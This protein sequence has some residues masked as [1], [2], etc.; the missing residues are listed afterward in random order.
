M[1]NHHHVTTDTQFWINLNHSVNCQNSI[2]DGIRTRGNSAT[3][4]IRPT[5]VVVFVWSK[6]QWGSVAYQGKEKNAVHMLLFYP[7][8]NDV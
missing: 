3:N 7:V 8:C 5:A 2:K 1:L 4:V 6:K